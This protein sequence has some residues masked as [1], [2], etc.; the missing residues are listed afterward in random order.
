MPAGQARCA[1][2][3]QQGARNRAADNP[4]DKRRGHERSDRPRPLARGKPACQ[5]VDEARKESRLGKAQKKPER[6]KSGRAADEH[7]RRRH[8]P[9]RNHDAGDPPP[10]ADAREDD[11]ARNLEQ[12]VAQKEDAGAEAVGPRG[13]SERLVHLQR[14][15]S[16]V[17]SVEVSDDV[18]KKEKGN[19]AAAN[20]RRR[21]REIGSGRHDVQYLIAR[22]GPAS[23]S[24]DHRPIRAMMA[25]SIPWSVPPA[26]AAAFSRLPSCWPSSPIWTAS[27]FRRLR[28]SSWRICTFRSS[29]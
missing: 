20:P 1:V 17:D 14:G 22:D 7:R 23:G 28:R 3:R 25:P 15:E 6:V 18:E 11:V 27:A 26:F 12:H 4:G 2:Q 16:D 13:K 8:Q 10:R 19:Q 5:I 29:R 24:L 9:P 21:G